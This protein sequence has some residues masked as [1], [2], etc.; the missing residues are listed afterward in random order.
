MKKNRD[1]PIDNWQSFWEL[2][3]STNPPKWV[4]VTGKCRG[5]YRAASKRIFDGSRGTGN[6][7]IRWTAAENCHCPRSYPQ[8]ENSSP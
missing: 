4:F 6:Q 8:S 7:I 5:I 2:I 1:M 3:K